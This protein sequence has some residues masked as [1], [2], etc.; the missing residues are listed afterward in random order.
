VARPLLKVQVAAL[1]IALAPL[2]AVADTNDEPAA[3]S[4]YIEGGANLHSLSSGY[5][6][7]Y[8]LYA[9]GAWK[10]D[11]RNTW[12]WEVDG[13]SEFDDSGLYA[14]G[15]VTHIFNADWYGELHVG[16]RGGGFFYPDYRVDAF[17]HRKVL[18]DRNLVLNAGTGYIDESDNHTE[19][20]L[21]LGATYYFDE[22]WVVE[23]GLRRTVSLPGFIYSSRLKLAGTYGREKKRLVTLALDTGREAYLSGVGT[24][25]FPSTV[26]TLTWR[27]WRTAKG[28][29]NVVVERYTSTVFDR[30]GVSFGVFREF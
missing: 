10:Q 29:F 11:E 7:W 9:K 4:G 17:I 6:N 26:L 30:T 13:E 28:G 15:G 18:P 21:Y 5:A 27:E 23:G 16:A 24:E 8:G 3:G 22:P 1:C 19:K 14:V 20:Y 25:N 12:D 2:V